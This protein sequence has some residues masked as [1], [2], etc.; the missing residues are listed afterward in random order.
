MK[1]M[2]GLRLILLRWLAALQMSVVQTGKRGIFQEAAALAFFAVLS[3]FPLLLVLLMV[4]FQLGA[5]AS[6]WQEA[7]LLAE[8]LMPP[9]AAKI[10][11]EYYKYSRDITSVGLFSA[12]FISGLW[13]STFAFQEALK[14]IRRVLR[15]RRRAS[16]WARIIGLLLM[17][18]IYFS[19]ILSVQL[20]AV[21]TWLIGLVSQFS[22]ISTNTALML[23]LLRGGLILVF[24]FTAVLFVY[25]LAWNDETK[26]SEHIPGSLLFSGS[27]ILV[28]RLLM[29]YF[30]MFDTH[31]IVFGAISS[32]FVTM[33]WFFVMCFLLLFC[34]LFNENY[35][36]LIKEKNEDALDDYVE[37]ADLE[38]E[39]DPFQA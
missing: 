38:P 21:G 9:A 3:A 7:M 6:A 4:S 30:K 14:S 25:A 31:Q 22:M 29:E 28:T 20:L 5:W 8:S 32:M 15:L 26:L 37:K 11:S 23:W 19:G 13:L 1:L 17:F 33:T 34:A 27:W 24:T 16:F 35:R 10:V 36:R 2:A 39:S 12:A 18:Y